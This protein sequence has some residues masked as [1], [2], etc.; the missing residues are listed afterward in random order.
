MASN[1]FLTVHF[2]DGSEMSVTFPKQGGNPLLLTKRVQQAIEAR[3]LAME[4]DGQLFVIPMDNVKYLQASP[5]PDE[6]PETVIL[7]GALIDEK[8]QTKESM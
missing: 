3:Q 8:G 1:R 6:L 2:I 7:G 5:C 4:L